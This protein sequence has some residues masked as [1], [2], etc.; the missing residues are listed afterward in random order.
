MSAHAGFAE[1]GDTERVIFVVRFMF[2][3]YVRT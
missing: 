2:G 1:N 3:F